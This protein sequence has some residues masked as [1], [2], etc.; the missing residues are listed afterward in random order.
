MAIGSASLKRPPAWLLCD[1]LTGPEAPEPINLL[2]SFFIIF[3]IVRRCKLIRLLVVFINTYTLHYW[4]INKT[5]K[6][7][8]YICIC[9]IP[10]KKYYES[11]YYTVHRFLIDTQLTMNGLVHVLMY[12][13]RFSLTFY[14]CEN[15]IIISTN[16]ALKCFNKS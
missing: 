11:N 15:L 3:K 9:F 13:F 14:I 4:E 6:S 1:D 8:F 7:N 10:N 5:Y 12:Q 2:P 16:T